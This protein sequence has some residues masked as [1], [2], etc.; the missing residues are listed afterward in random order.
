M[1]SNQ[2]R[3][4]CHRFAYPR[5]RSHVVG[6]QFELRA[7]FERTSQYFLISGNLCTDRFARHC[8]PGRQHSNP[9]CKSWQRMATARCAPLRLST[10][11][12]VENVGCQCHSLQ[13]NSA[14]NFSEPSPPSSGHRMNRLSDSPRD[15]HELHCEGRCADASITSCYLYA[16]QCT[17]CIAVKPQ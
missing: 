1:L 14:Y 8:N 9:K 12:H 13:R 17:D 5:L 16:A 7:A 6:C 2:R 15:R 10:M 3:P 4:A 11:D